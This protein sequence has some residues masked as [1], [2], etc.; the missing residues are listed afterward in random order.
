MKLVWQGTDAYLMHSFLPH[1]SSGWKLKTILMRLL[2]WILDS[3]FDLKHEVVSENLIKDLSKAGITNIVS[4]RPDLLEY[5]KRIQKV[6]HEFYNILYY[7]LSIVRKN[8]KSLRWLYGIDI[9]EK[10][11]ELLQPYENIQFIRVDG[12]QNMNEIYPI[13]DFLIRPNRHDGI[14]RMV[15]EAEI[16]EIEYY[17]SQENPENPER[18]TEI[19][20]KAYN[21]W[22]LKY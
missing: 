6:E 5:P 22:K 2:V 20:L 19:I 12:N 3:Y 9:I 13:T 4:I 10:V 15:M 18:I 14:S 1:M 17:W 21:K 8:K 16:Q 11:M 7:D